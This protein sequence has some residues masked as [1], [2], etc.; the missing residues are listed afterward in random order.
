MIVMTF[1]DAADSPTG[2]AKVRIRY[3]MQRHADG[4][5][6]PV[7]QYRTGTATLT[8]DSWAGY[9]MAG[10]VITADTDRERGIVHE[11]LGREA[12]T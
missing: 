2:Q 12:L 9:R 3:S 11:V 4:G 7:L 6:R 5:I 8:P 1:P 10:A